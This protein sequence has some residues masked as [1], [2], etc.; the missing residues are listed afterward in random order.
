MENERRRN[1]PGSPNHG[2]DQPNDDSLERTR[3]EMEGIFEAA[4]A[5]LNSVGPLDAEQYLQRNRQHG[6]Q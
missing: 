4:D 5:V 6:G 2:D 1:R 3:R